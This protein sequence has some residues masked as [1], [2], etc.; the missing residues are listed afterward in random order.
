LKEIATV[1]LC[2][3]CWNEI[4][5][6]D[7]CPECGVDLK[8]LAQ[9]GY[10]EKLIRALRHPEPTVPIRVAAI[11]GKLR[12]R[13]AVEPLIEMAL[14]STD[15]YIQ[16]AAVTALGTIGDARALPCLSQLSHEGALRVRIA[17][18]RAAKNLENE[19]SANQG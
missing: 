5:N 2:P 8:E 7:V 15:P 13:A 11:L 12:S 10:E 17:A 16:E 19:L 3:S 6:E 14:S 9:E 4:R 18:E 1:Y